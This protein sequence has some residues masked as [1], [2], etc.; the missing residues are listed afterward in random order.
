M[1]TVACRNRL[2]V[3]YLAKRATACRTLFWAFV[4]LSRVWRLLCPHARDDIRITGWDV[5]CEERQAVHVIFG[6]PF[7][8][9]CRCQMDCRRGG[10]LGTSTE[11]VQTLWHV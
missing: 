11:Y 9:A 3:F 1:G 7:Y 10:S 2:A 5:A 4:A 6:A 8:L